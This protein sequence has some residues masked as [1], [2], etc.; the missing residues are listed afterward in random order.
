MVRVQTRSRA[1]PKGFSGRHGAKRPMSKK[2]KQVPAAKGLVIVREKLKARITKSGPSFGWF[3]PT[4]EGFVKLYKEPVLTRVE[5]IKRGLGARDAKVII[6]QLRVPRGEAL[7]A[8]HIPVATMNRKAKTNAPLSR[9]E[10]ERVLGF[11]RLVGQIQTMIRESGN[12]VGFDASE[13]LSNWMSAP[14]PALNG[15]RP[16]DLIDTMSGQALVSQV[17]SQMQ[18]GAYA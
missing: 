1:A 16:L 11:G 7:T 10:G 9:A 17:L 13:W 4:E 6:G 14:V 18:S 15:V 5:W 12:P 8:L 2:A 3:K